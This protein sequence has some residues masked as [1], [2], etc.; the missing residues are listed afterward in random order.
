MKIP[1]RLPP[2]AVP[3]ALQLLQV[4]ASSRAGCK[5]T[6]LFCGRRSGEGRKRTSSKGGY[7]GIVIYEHHYN[8]RSVP[9]CQHCLRGLTKC[10]RNRADYWAD[11]RENERDPFNRVPPE[12]L[13]DW[14]ASRLSHA[15]FD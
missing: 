6:C 3:L 1:W 8:G 10:W 15:S 9:T 14:M 11:Y 2:E 4:V 5:G 12:V 7:V 13:A